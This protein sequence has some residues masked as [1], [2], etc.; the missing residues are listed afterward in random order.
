MDYNHW[1]VC[2]RYWAADS[3]D[4]LVPPQIAVAS[5]VLGDFASEIHQVLGDGALNSFL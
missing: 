2:K 3:G 4:N 5:K 1:I